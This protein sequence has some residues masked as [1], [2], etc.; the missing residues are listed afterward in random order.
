MFRVGRGG[1]FPVREQAGGLFAGRPLRAMKSRI[2]GR[3]GR[4]CEMPTRSVALV[5]YMSM[6]GTFV[7]LAR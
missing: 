6:I 1:V 4:T 7:P 2:V 5:A 3:I